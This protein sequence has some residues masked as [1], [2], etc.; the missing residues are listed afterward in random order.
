MENAP[1]RRVSPLDPAL[2]A[3]RIPRSPLTESGAFVSALADRSCSTTFV[4]PFPEAMIN[5]V[6][7]FCGARQ[8]SLRHTRYPHKCMRPLP[9]SRPSVLS[10]LE[11]G[12]HGMD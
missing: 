6:S 12:K 9:H 7:P 11:R 2:S 5:G 8:C 4:C 10:N 1:T 3:S